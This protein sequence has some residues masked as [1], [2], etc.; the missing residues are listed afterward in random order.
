MREIKLE[1]IFN[2][3]KIESIKEMIDRHNQER[4]EEAAEIIYL[5]YENNELL[6]G[7]SKDLQLAYKAGVVDS[8]KWQAERMYTDEDLF[9]ILLDFVAFPHDHMESRGSI[10]E[11]YLKELKN[12]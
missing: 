7:H 10:I 9:K 2:E 11:R 1:D 6:Y 4:L 5:S 3:E 12:K 8:V